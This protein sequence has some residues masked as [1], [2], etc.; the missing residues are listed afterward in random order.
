MIQYPTTFNFWSHSIEAGLAIVANSANLLCQNAGLAAMI[1]FIESWKFCENTVNMQ[2]VKTISLEFSSCSSK[3]RIS[4]SHQ[5]NHPAIVNPSK[6]RDR[7]WMLGHYHLL[8]SFGNQIIHHYNFPWN[9]KHNE[10][11]KSP[12]VKVSMFENLGVQTLPKQQLDQQT[13]KRKTS[14]FW[15]HQMF[16]TSHGSNLQKPC[17]KHSPN[18]KKFCVQN[19]NLVGKPFSWLV[20]LPPHHLPPPEI[21]AYWL[22]HWFPLDK[23]LWSTSHDQWNINKS[24]E[25]LPKLQWGIQPSIAIKT[26]TFCNDM[27]MTWTS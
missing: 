3:R 16:F 8:S 2:S 6:Y 14:S 19:V 4:K 23:G 12:L 21:R 22:N 25:R 26:P 9:L 17:N 7:T 5:S 24:S 20:N 13:S 1:I 11:Q 27:S 18:L 15:D 10:F